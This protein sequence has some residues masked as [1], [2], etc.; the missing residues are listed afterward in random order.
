MLYPCLLTSLFQYLLLISISWSYAWWHHIKMKY[1]S[2]RHTMTLLICELFIP[3]NFMPSDVDPL[4]ISWG[5]IIWNSCHLYES[6]SVL[7]DFPGGKSY[8]YNTYWAFL[9]LWSILYVFALVALTDTRTITSHLI[10][11]KCRAHIEL[12]YIV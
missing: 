9:E 7:L 6:Y 5:I 8:H 4:S 3:Y 11:A 2:S 1:W 12:M 10:I